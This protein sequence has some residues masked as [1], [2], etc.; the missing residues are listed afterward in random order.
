M[1]GG[2]RASVDCE[3]GLRGLVWADAGLGGARAGG[4]GT[5][6]SAEEVV[7]HPLEPGDELLLADVARG[8]LVVEE[9]G[10]DGG[11]EGA[12]VGTPKGV[13]AD[14]GQALLE[15]LHVGADVEG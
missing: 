7:K 1:G 6:T 5:D 3:M 13:A 15:V 11:D 10:P 8:P 4:T 9:A 2:G 12:G 14:V